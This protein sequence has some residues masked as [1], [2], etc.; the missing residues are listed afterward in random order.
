MSN[1]LAFCSSASVRNED[2]FPVEHRYPERTGETAGVRWNERQKWCYVSGVKE[3]E[4]ILLECFDSEGGKDTGTVRG[5]RAPHTAFG[6]SGEME[7]AKGRE[8]IEVRALVFSEGE[9]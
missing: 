8:S 1:P 5:G 2:V 3:D 7:R 9:G 4:S 6:H